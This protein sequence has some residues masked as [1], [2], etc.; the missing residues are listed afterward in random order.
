MFRDE[1]VVVVHVQ[2]GALAL[3]GLLPDGHLNGDQ[4][5]SHHVVFRRLQ[6]QRGLFVDVGA[7]AGIRN[8]RNGRRLRY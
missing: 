5:V 6:Q 2:L 3:P 8:A 7:T 1:G 4:I